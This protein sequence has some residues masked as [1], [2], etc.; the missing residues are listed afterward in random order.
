M[1]NILKNWFFYCFSLWL[2]SELFP[3]LVLIGTWQTI[4]IAGALLSLLMLIVRPALSILFIP[5]NIIT[6]GLLSWLINVIVFY[7]FTILVP[8]VLITPWTFPGFAMNGFVIPSIEGSYLLSL[9]IA[10]FIVSGIAN[11]FRSITD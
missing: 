2:T 11:F 3:G 9:L 4:L 7:L 1:K 6:F 10:S 8:N 5:I